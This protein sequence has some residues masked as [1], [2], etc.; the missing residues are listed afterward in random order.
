MK[1]R[2]ISLTKLF[3]VGALVIAI[4]ISPGIISQNP[5]VEEKGIP[6]GWS[7]DIKLTDDDMTH[8]DCE[9]ATNEEDVHVVWEQWDPVASD[10]YIVHLKSNDSGMTWSS[11]MNVSD[12]NYVAICPDVGVSEQDVHVVWED[13]RGGDA[14]VYYRNSTDGGATWNLEK[15]IPGS[16]IYAAGPEIY[17]NNSNIHIFWGDA[18]DGWDGEIYYRRS[19]DGGITFDNGQGV[20]ED[21]RITFSPAPIAGPMIGGDGSN[22]S[23]LW[24][25]ERDGDWE[26]YWMISKDNG[27]TWENG[28]GVEHVGRKLTDNNIDD[29]MS[30]VAV[31]GSNINIIWVEEI[32]PGPEYQLYYR[33]ST[34]SGVTW[35]NP[36]NL[37]ELLPLIQSPDIDVEGDNIS[38]VWGDSRDYG[39]FQTEVYYK[40]STDG[41]ISW[42]DDTRLTFDPI[43]SNLP[44]ISVVNET[45]HVVWNSDEIYYK[46]YPDFPPDPT[47]NISLQE[48][49][50]LISI[51]LVQS[52][53]SIDEV[54]ENI[55]GKWDIIQTYDP[56]SS[57]PWKTNNTYRPDS[58][59]D[60]DTL[61]H[62]VGFWINITEPNVNLTVR[63]YIPTSTSTNLY[64]GWNLVGYPSLTNETVANALWGTGADAVMVC[65]TSEPYHIKEAGPTYT[66]KPGEGYWLH[67]IADSVWV[68]DW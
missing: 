41:G 58:L 65:D 12:T 6:T 28:L 50:N 56:L 22:L 40:N 37:T 66:M 53:E 23:V 44:R 18:R 43:Q 10:D 38:I 3:V 9:I 13:Y 21:R 49:W 30:R 34:D 60:F 48:G 24:C 55:T 64:A 45:K 52:D 32:W 35:N 31:N 14:M 2:T 1:G 8:V 4:A 17:V 25:D 20:D 39:G 42:S 54:L 63:G 27:Y 46:R 5:V 7:D 19:L 51:P 47:Y 26:V 67:V 33:N 15:R 29:T 11:T 62:K 36:I 61:N 59:N 57:E 68:V 16:T